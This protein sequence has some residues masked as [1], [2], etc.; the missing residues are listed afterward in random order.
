MYEKSIFHVNS[1]VQYWQSGFL[2]PCTSCLDSRHNLNMKLS[3]SKFKITRCSCLSWLV[4]FIEFEV[5]LVRK[6]APFGLDLVLW[7]DRTWFFKELLKSSGRRA[8]HGSWGW[9]CAAALTHGIHSCFTAWKNWKYEKSWA[10]A[11]CFHLPVY[12]SFA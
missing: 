5:L 12:S 3:W 1:I 6:E 11:G 10:G 4:S 8:W 7:E 9:R 2:Y